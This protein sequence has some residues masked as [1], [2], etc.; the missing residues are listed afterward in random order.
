MRRL[1]SS[2]AAL[3]A[4]RAAEE[5]FGYPA[6]LLMEEA[7]IRLQDKLTS[8][9]LP[10]GPVAYLVGPGNNGGDGWV[11]ARQAWLAGTRN[12][13]VVEALPSASPSCR[14][15]ASLGRRAGVPVESWP[16]A[17]A[18][19]ALGQAA[20]WVDGTWGA[21]LKA[22]LRP[23]AADIV[24]DLET[25]RAER[26]TPVAAIDVPGGLWEGWTPDQPV[27]GAR[28]TLAPGPLK[29]F[30]FFPD[31]RPRVGVPVEVPLAFPRGA[32]PI[33]QILEASDLP[34]LLPPVLPTDHKGRR[35]HVALV[36]GAPGMTGALVLASRSAAAAGAGLVTLGLD[37]ELR[38]LVAPAVPAFQVRSPGELPG[39]AD[40]FHALV[41]GPGW[42]RTDDRP[43]VLA[44]LW[45]LRLPLVL[46]ADGLVAWESLSPGPRGAP[47]VITPHP[48]EFRR[49]G[50]RG[51]H[52]V[53]AAAT[54]A[55]D[56]G[57]TVVLKGAVT[58][59][60]DPEGR[61]AVWDGANPAL[62]TGGSGDC[63][64]GVVG[65]FLARGLGGFEAAC[66]AVV[67]HAEAGRNLGATGGW[68][69]A[70]R[71]PRALALVSAACRTRSGRL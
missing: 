63:L 52:P 32:E 26:D 42:G 46:D 35:G 60:L 66:A 25:L 69:T 8:L 51:S 67:L 7:G 3:A 54:L 1:V 47:T 22:P 45:D 9:G 31:L 5:E 41:V 24:A 70:D 21:G 14:L 65:A 17:S 15:M 33:A 23:G 58:W 61:R 44:K 56:R 53:E 64:A 36:G 16:S 55:R 18:R 71:L 40:R 13:V 12:L 37:Q 57:V 11:M 4:D 29:D 39:L 30:C 59:I 27:L 48:G 43:G 68:F 34:G 6:F 28:W 50:A 19:E 10:P 2:A 20:V 38:A 62:G 49:L